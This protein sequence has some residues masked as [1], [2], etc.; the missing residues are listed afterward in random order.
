MVVNLGMLFLNVLYVDTVVG[1]MTVN[2]YFGF[3]LPDIFL[4]LF[5]LDERNYLFKVYKFTN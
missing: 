3:I 2:H 5:C 1:H 4:F